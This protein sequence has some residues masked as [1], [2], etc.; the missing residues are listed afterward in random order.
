MTVNCS[1]TTSLTGPKS[2]PALQFQYEHPTP[3]FLSSS[4]LAILFFFI[5]HPNHL[6]ELLLL[7]LFSKWRVHNYIQQ[8]IQGCRHNLPRHW[9]KSATYLTPFYI[10]VLFC[11]V[12][13][14]FV[15]FCIVLCCIVLYCIVLYC[16]ILFSLYVYFYFI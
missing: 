6:T 3:P 15:L 13:F 9:C 11:F 10:P 2:Q 7:R 1:S 4:I 5:L 8:R 14:C 12:L 16:I